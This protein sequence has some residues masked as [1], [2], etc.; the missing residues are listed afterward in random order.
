M[1]I[2]GKLKD[3]MFWMDQ[4]SSDN[5]GNMDGS[6]F[7]KG[8]NALAELIVD[9]ERHVKAKLADEYGDERRGDPLG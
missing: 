5:M 7:N 8:K 1:D 4:V 2:L 3:V 6:F 9:G